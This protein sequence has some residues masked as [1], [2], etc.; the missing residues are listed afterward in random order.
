MDGKPVHGVVACGKGEREKLWIICNIP[1]GLGNVKITCFLTLNVSLMCGSQ[2]A[3]S[4]AI[5]DVFQDQEFLTIILTILE[6]R[7]LP[8]FITLLP[9]A[10]TY[11]FL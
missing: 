2:V 6:I 10:N 9:M 11:L 8:E 1:M 3:C 7:K 4:L 5:K